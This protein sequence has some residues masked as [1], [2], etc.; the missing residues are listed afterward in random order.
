[1]LKVDGDFG[2]TPEKLKSEYLDVYEG[3]SAE[4]VST[5]HFDEDTGLHTTYLGQVNMSRNTEVR[6]EE[7]FFHYCKRVY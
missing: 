4:I 1:M 7:S 2:G 5:N 3:V 6:A